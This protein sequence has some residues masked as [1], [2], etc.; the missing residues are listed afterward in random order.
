MNYRY[1]LYCVP[2]RLFCPGT[3]YL[4]IGDWVTPAGYLILSHGIMTEEEHEKITI[5]KAVCIYQN[6]GC[7]WIGIYPT[8]ASKKD[9]D[10][11]CVG[12]L[13]HIRDNIYGG[14]IHVR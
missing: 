6:I 1:T 9:K 10:T 13:H 11:V 5:G 2:G 14:G 4:S 8:H 3:H 7:S 12:V